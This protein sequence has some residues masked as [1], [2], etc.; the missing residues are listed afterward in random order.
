VPIYRCICNYFVT[1]FKFINTMTYMGS[2]WK[3]EIIL[4]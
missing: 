2:A 4:R 1:V 3:T